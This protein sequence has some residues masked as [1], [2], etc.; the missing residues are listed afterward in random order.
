MHTLF[1]AH[2]QPL[3]RQHIDPFDTPFMRAADK[4]HAEAQAAALGRDEGAP[5]P[6]QPSRAGDAGG[7]AGMAP[8][9]MRVAY[10]L[11]MELQL[12][13]DQDPIPWA[14]FVADPELVGAFVGLAQVSLAV[15]GNSPQLATLRSVALLVLDRDP[16][17][18]EQLVQ[19]LADLDASLQ[20]KA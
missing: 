14:A 15:C 16:E 9:V 5:V 18:G 10:A 8:M 2:G 12:M 3:P 6:D 13:T 7:A 17:L 4:A 11:N 1:D 19:A 20:G